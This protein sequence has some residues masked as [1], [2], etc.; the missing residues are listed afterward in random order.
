MHAYPRTCVQLKEIVKNKVQRFYVLLNSCVCLSL[1]RFICVHTHVEA[2]GQPQL[3][4]F[5]CHLTWFLREPLSLAYSL[6]TRYDLMNCWCMDPAYLSLPGPGT[7]NLYHHSTTSRFLVFLFIV[8]VNYA[9]SDF[10]LA[11]Q[12]LCQLSHLPGLR[13]NIKKLYLVT[14][15][16]WRFAFNI[17]TMTTGG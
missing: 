2:K 5:G 17:S 7:T 16:I 10:M 4:F 15:K 1:W 6:A 11:R 14:K 8:N 3:S 9:E 13:L 12:V